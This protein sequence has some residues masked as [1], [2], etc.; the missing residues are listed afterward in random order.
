MLSPARLPLTTGRPD[1]RTT[2]RPDDRTTGR[3]DD[4]TTGRPARRSLIKLLQYVFGYADAKL[5]DMADVFRGEYITKKGMTEG[6]IPVILGGQEPAYYID[7]S[8]P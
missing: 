5:S 2:G 6:N 4:R 1:D 7:Q 8:N 3:P